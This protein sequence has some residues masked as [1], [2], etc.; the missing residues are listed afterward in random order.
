ME[1][2][3]EKTMEHEMETWELEVLFWCKDSGCHHASSLY[4]PA[5]VSS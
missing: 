1:D 3:M 4:R 2:Q 5:V